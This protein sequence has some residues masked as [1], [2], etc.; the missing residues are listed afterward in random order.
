MAKAHTAKLDFTQEIDTNTWYVGDWWKVYNGYA[1]FISEEPTNNFAKRY[2]DTND[3]YDITD[4]SVYTRIITPPDTNDDYKAVSLEVYEDGFDAWAYMIG[5]DDVD[6]YAYQEEDDLYESIEHDGGSYYV[7]IRETSGTMYYEYS[8]DGKLWNILMQHDTPAN[9]LNVYITVD[10]YNAYKGSRRITIG[11]VNMMIP[12][13]TDKRYEYAFVNSDGRHIVGQVDN[14]ELYEEINK[15]GSSIQITVPADLLNTN[16]T[17]DELLLIDENGNEI[18]TE[19]GDAIIISSEISLEG[20][21]QLGNSIVVKEQSLIEPLG[22]TVFAGSVLSY[23]YSQDGGKVS[24]EAI[25]ASGML[26]RAI[27]DLPLVTLYLDQYDGVTTDTSHIIY[28]TPAST[29][30]SKFAQTFTLSEDKNLAYIAVWG[31]TY[32]SSNYWH[33]WGSGIRLD[34]Y[35]G[36]PGG[37]STLLAT[38]DNSVT[39]SFDILGFLWFKISPGVAIES[40]TNYYFELSAPDVGAPTDSYA[41]AAAV[42]ASSSYAD[43]TAYTYTE[44]GGYTDLSVDSKFLL[45]SYEP[46]VETNTFYTQDPSVMLKS[47]LDAAKDSGINVTYND[48][49]IAST[50]SVL[51]YTF[52]FGTY[53][54]AIS[55]C[56]ELAPA[57]WWYYI[58]AGSNNIVFQSKPTQIYDYLENGKVH[59]LQVKRSLQN[60]INQAYVV[61][62]EVSGTNVLKRSQ[63]LSSIRKY[64]TWVASRTDNRITDETSA[65]LVADSMVDAFAEPRFSAKITLPAKYYDINQF[66]PGKLVGF[67]GYNEVINSLQ[68]QIV[69][70]KLTADY[71]ELTLELLPPTQTKRIEDLRRNLL[72]TDT[73]NNP[74]VGSA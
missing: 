24:V 10:T 34:L 28:G 59:S 21:P 6:L 1:R 50:G 41:F 68:L 44:D 63:N 57:N 48:S 17:V 15:A 55:K 30:V 35:Q 46:G 33:L 38:T 22:K 69:A 49:E 40:G 19:T 2:I 37:T 32:G 62:G 42:G 26:D 65:Q 58:D 7:R 43:G 14:F 4:S 29:S 60:V 36:T 71:A 5:F 72:M 54:E 39:Y 25:S 13:V 18:I 45:Y 53:Y 8:K 66:T 20:I 9:I 27:M 11:G 74:D 52:T 47:I 31:T 23:E 61:G 3:A 56:V 12:P 64:G 73:Q 51:S 70:R 16:S 67:T